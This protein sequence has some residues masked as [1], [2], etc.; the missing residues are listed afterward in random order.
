MTS[1]KRK[2]VAFIGAVLMTG[3]I[4]MSVSAASYKP[5][6]SN[7]AG[8]VSGDPKIKYTTTNGNFG[9]MYGNVSQTKM[10]TNQ[11][12][13]SHGYTNCYKVAKFY[14]WTYVH[15]DFELIATTNAQKE[16]SGTSATVSTAS[17][18]TSNT[19]DKRSNVGYLYNFVNTQI[20]H[21]YSNV[22]KPVYY[23]L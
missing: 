14:P 15:G 3:T 9:W 19:W 17:I 1:I 8:E 23:G 11:N 13:K 2:I 22:V 20:E 6:G 7:S 4:I 10:T 12:G 5:T 18:S 16:N 21:H